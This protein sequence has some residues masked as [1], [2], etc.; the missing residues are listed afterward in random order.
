MM[1]APKVTLF[2]G[3]T[4][5]V[6]DEVQRPFVT[7]VQLGSGNQHGFQPI[8]DVIHEGMR[9]GLRAE[10]T[11]DGDVDLLCNLTE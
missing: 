4:A 2:N 6:A 5:W 1:F 3:Q 10:V 11:E 8:I 9:I 7:G